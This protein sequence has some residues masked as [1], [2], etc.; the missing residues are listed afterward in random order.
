[1]TFAKNA[2]EASFFDAVAAQLTPKVCSSDVSIDCS[3]SELA[4]RSL[5]MFKQYQ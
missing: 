5:N 2:S 4:F 1:M 3:D